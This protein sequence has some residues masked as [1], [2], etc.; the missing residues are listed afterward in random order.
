MRISPKHAKPSMRRELL[1]AVELEHAPAAVKEA[2]WQQHN[3]GRRRAR[4]RPAALGDLAANV[5]WRGAVGRSAGRLD[6]LA[7]AWRA[8]VPPMYLSETRIAFFRDGRLDVIVRHAAARF[9]LQRRYQEKLLAELN[10]RLSG[11]RVSRINFR[12]V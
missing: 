6:Q 4:R 7:E 8:V 5:A 12:T 3:H 10:Q 11:F 9:V 2:F 1:Q